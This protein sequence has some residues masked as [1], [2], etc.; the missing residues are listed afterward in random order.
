MSIK[1][2]RNGF[3]AVLALSAFAF[4]AFSAQA[5]QPQPAEAQATEAQ[6]TEAEPIA[7]D[8]GL[9]NV[10]DVA[11]VELATTCKELKCY[12]G[13]VCKDNCYPSGNACCT[14]GSLH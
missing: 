13:L 7:S 5:S 1:Q 9:D 4:S 14:T 3:F 2:A 10:T 12:N 11:P 8:L 6:A